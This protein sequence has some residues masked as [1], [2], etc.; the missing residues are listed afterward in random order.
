MPLFNNVRHG[1]VAE[2]KSHIKSISA[3][4]IPPFSKISSINFLISG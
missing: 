2:F 3:R 4:K 1:K